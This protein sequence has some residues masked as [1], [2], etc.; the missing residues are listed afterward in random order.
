MT[1]AGFVFLLVLFLQLI[2]NLRASWHTNHAE[3]AWQ[4]C[5]VGAGPGGLQMGFFLERAGRD[6]VIL[7]KANTS[8][9]FFVTYP[10][11]RKL[12]SINK[13]HTG[14]TNKEFNL[15]HDWNSLLSDDESLQM[16]YYSKDF[17]PH[18]DTYVRYLN[19]YA[20]KLQ[21]NIKYNT[22]VQNISRSANN[23]T[24][25]F[26]DQD[27]YGY[28]CRILILS[29]GLSLPH[30]PHFEGIQHT[31]G[32][33]TVS[34]DPDEFEGKS[35]LILGRG[36]SAF[37]T[38][39][40][41]LGSTNVIHMVARSRLRMA[42]ET[43][44]VGDLRAVNNGLLDTYQLKSLDGILEGDI[45]EMAILKRTDGRLILVDQYELE[46]VLQENVTDSDINSHMTRIMPDNFALREPYDKIIRCMGFKYDNNI[47]NDDTKP[48][49]GRK[50]LKKYPKMFANYES[51]DV[52]DLFF[53]GALSH[54]V[55]YRK[56]AGGFIH[57][58]R[59][60]ARALFRI[61]EARYQS[62]P[63]PSVRLPITE[64]INH[65]IKRINEA[66]GTYQMFGILADIII[67]HSD[68]MEYEYIEEFPLKLLPE[69]SSVTRLNASQVIVVSMEYG[70]DFSGPGKDI[71]GPQRA[72]A[73]PELG[74]LSNFLHP[75]LY[76]YSALPTAEA[77]ASLDP[78]DI[79]PA[80]DRLHHIVE[81]FLTDWTAPVSHILMLRRF[82]E[83][84]LGSDLRYF[85][86]TSCFR[87]IMTHTTL[88]IQCQQHYLQDQGLEGSDLHWEYVA[89][90]QLTENGVVRS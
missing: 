28:S 76:Y 15:R 44:Y 82:L 7:E 85:F 25:T 38:A 14:K 81:D 2:G 59:Y 33:R 45:R 50:K 19:D 10:R 71:F 55:D 32:Y 53:A 60:T 70:K 39:D 31:E 51:V 47:F 24:F 58:F 72:T 61:L 5:I 54:A 46:A 77:M 42:W 65:I 57:G 41:I 73:L 4:Y 86:D 83:S 56:S 23:G 9:A 88:P 90:M 68:G 63:W 84:C 48:H 66:S 52:P 27:G 6:Y 12:I 34:L 22:N 30:E 87:L 40:H 26:Q 35:I 67:L 69:L 13:R 18:A 3:R 1:T 29:S 75:V 74:H 78:K 8:G 80:P 43:H 62:V 37:E 17:F 49:R 36:N 20:R 11:H 89:Q 64:L 79:L 21:L 16:K